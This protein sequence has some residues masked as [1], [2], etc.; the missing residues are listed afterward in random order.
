MAFAELHDWSHIDLVEGREHRGLRLGLHE[1]LGDLATQRR[2]ALTRGATITRWDGDWCGRSRRGGGGG[3]RSDRGGGRSDGANRSLAGEGGEH[4][5][6]GH[7][8]GFAGT[9]DAS[10]IQS[11]FGGETTDGGRNF[12]GRTGFGGDG[13]SFRCGHG[14]GSWSSLGRRC[15]G[16]WCGGSV[17]GRASFDRGDDLI[18]EH[19]RTG[20]DGDGDLAVDFRGAFGGHLVGFVGKEGLALANSVTAFDQP[21]G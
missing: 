19:F 4:V 11:G 3:S 13:C 16:S 14:G 17:A 1:A 20:F 15:G 7:A 18:D 8:A 21:G 12:G 5:T 6:F 9:F 10:G 2:H